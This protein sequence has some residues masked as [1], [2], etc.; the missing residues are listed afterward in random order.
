MVKAVFLIL[1]TGNKGTT[2]RDYIILQRFC[3]QRQ[4]NI[5]GSGKDDISLDTL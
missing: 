2:T 4:L 1:I 5:H 3:I